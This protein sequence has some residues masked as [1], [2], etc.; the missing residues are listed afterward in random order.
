MKRIFSW[1]GL[2]LP[3]V[4]SACLYDVHQ[5]R[6]IQAHNAHHQQHDH[7]HEL[8]SRHQHTQHHT[9]ENSLDW[10]GIYQG[11][12]PCSNCDGIATTLT[13][14]H[15]KTFVWQQTPTQNQQR[16]P[17]QVT[18]GRFDFDVKKPALIHLA[19][20]NGKET[21][22]VGEGFVQKHKQHVLP[23]F[24]SRSPRLNQVERF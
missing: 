13:L 14:N 24:Q 15:N 7:G 8:R 20:D 18:T 6:Q 19:T 1:F 22:F 2:S 10:A 12:M 4:L 17:T 11:N 16:L 5:Q 23:W 9:A 21:F 3:L